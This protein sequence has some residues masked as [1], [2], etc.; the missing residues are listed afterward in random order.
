MCKEDKG[1]V[2]SPTANHSRYVAFRFG[3]LLFGWH[4]IVGITCV[5]L[6]STA[7]YHPYLSWTVVIPSQICN[8]LLVN[9]AYSL[10]NQ[11]P[12]ST[13]IFPGVVAPHKEA[14]QRTIWVMQYLIARVAMKVFQQQVHDNFGTPD[15]EYFSSIL[16]SVIVSWRYYP[17]VPQLHTDWWNGNTWIFVI[18]IFIG[19]SGDVY[20]YFMHGDIFEIFHLLL[21]ELLGLCLAF[22]FTLG[23]R[24]Y[25]P[26]PIVYCGAALAVWAIIQQGIV[27]VNSASSQ[28]I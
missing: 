17:L 14:F 11:V 13:Q 24:R 3:N 20:V 7:I 23:F 2:T 16:A 26:M 25:I 1:S 18:P 19:V 8:L 28:G 21:G 12:K 10:L 5:I 22:G 9:D 15:I 6:T 4:G 27:T